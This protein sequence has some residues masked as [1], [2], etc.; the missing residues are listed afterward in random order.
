MNSI[1]LIGNLAE[2]IELREG[3]GDPVA[4]FRLA[5]SR[6][7][8]DGAGARQTV[9]QWHTCVAFGW[10]A[11]AV[12]G[13]SKGLLVMVHGE[14]TEREYTDK[15][16]QRRWIHEVRVNTTAIVCSTPKVEGNEAY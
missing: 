1:Y 13:L 8:T 15:N 2:R 9:T 6:K 16:G 3:N 4:I 11:Q 10:R 5:T 7:Y 14:A 12:E